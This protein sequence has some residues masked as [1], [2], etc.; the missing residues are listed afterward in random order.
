MRVSDPHRGDGSSLRARRRHPTRG[1]APPRRINDLSGH[2][3]GTEPAWIDRVRSSV[4]LVLLGAALIVAAACQGTIGGIAGGGDGS[5]D[6][7]PGGDDPPADA[8]RL[9]RADGATIDD[10]PVDA[11]PAG[12]TCASPGLLFC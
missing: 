10:D 12:I 5:G 2:V 9:D 7:D 1:A 3:A 8:A 4:S 6:D 11:A